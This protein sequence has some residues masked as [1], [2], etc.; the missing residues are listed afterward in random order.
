MTTP[1]EM[2]PEQEHALSWNDRLLDAIDGDVDAAERAAI[3]AH[4][5]ECVQCRNQLAEFDATR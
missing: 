2:T 4:V 3:D 5:V 1:R